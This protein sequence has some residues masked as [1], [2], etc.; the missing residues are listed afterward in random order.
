MVRGEGEYKPP[1]KLIGVIS[2]TLYLGLG[3]ILFLGGIVLLAGALIAP[4]QHNR[5]DRIV[6]GAGGMA[7]AVVG[8]GMLGVGY[9]QC[10]RLAREGRTA[11]AEVI[12]RWW[13]R[14]GGRGPHHH[15][16]YKFVTQL[17][18][19]STP[20][21]ACRMS[22]KKL[23]DRLQIGDKFTVRYL[24]SNLRVGE[25]EARGNGAEQRDRK[26]TPR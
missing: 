18:D 26:P 21:V 20:T 12:G 17:P 11:Q 2:P 6:T 16:A 14:W 1:G 13:S 7:W 15:V 5:T 8:A 4:M 19:G 25:F 22:G 10:K 3:A 9:R 24:P 23:Y